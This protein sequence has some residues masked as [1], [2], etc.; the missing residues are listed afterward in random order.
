MLIPFTTRRPANVGGLSVEHM[1]QVYVGSE[2]DLSRYL[3]LTNAC[4]DAVLEDGDVLP[5][6]TRAAAAL[7]DKGA[8]PGEAVSR[9]ATCYGSRQTS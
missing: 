8:D 5:A 6:V 2:E 3:L 1:H 7:I 9:V 4:I